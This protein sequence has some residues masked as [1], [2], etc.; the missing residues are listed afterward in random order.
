MSTTSRTHTATTPAHAA[1]LEDAAMLAAARR[2]ALHAVSLWSARAYHA[3]AGELGATLNTS[4]EE[5]CRALSRTE[6]ALI[7]LSQRLEQRGRA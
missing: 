4:V 2:D 5:A 3:Q 1:V 7:A 6:Q